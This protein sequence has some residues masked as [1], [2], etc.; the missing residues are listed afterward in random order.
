MIMAAV[1]FYFQYNFEKLLYLPKEVERDPYYQAI[2]GTGE[3]SKEAIKQKQIENEQLEQDMQN[4]VENFEL[5]IVDS[6]E[7]QPNKLTLEA[8]EVSS[9]EEVDAFI[10]ELQSEFS[11]IIVDSTSVEGNSDSND[12]EINKKKS[13]QMKMIIKNNSLLTEEE[14]DFLDVADLELATYQDFPKASISDDIDGPQQWFVYV[15]GKESEY[16]HVSDGANGAKKW[17]HVGSIANDISIDD[18][19]MLSVEVVN[20]KIHVN[21]LVIMNNFH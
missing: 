7:A 15:E 9:D 16:L 14:G 21:D 12:I 6:N 19:L 8:I 13:E 20:G 10:E 1:Y 4:Y 11:D 17:V 3:F 5:S 18:M 2:Y